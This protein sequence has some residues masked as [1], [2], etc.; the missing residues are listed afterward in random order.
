MYDEVALLQPST[1]AGLCP[2][3]TLPGGAPSPAAPAPLPPA[4]PFVEALAARGFSRVVGKDLWGPAR[5]PHMR[6]LL[7]RLSEG[8]TALVTAGLPPGLIAVFDEAWAL[9]DAVHAYL[10]GALPGHTVALLDWAVFHVPPAGGGAG[11]A[12]HRDRP[13]VCGAA[14]VDPATRLPRYVTAWL[15]LTPATPET[16]CLHFLPRDD[17]PGFND[18]ALPPGEC[19][20]Q[21]A[22]TAPEHFQRIVAVPAAPGA[23][24]AFGSRTLHYG[25]RPLP[26]LPSTGAARLPR[27]ALSFAFAVEGFEEPPCAAP[28]STLRARVA[29]AA[30]QAIVYAAQAPLPRGA[31]APLL[32]AFL[33]EAGAFGEAYARRVTAAGRWLCFKEKY[34]EGAAGGGGGAPD[35]GGV[36]LAFAGLAAAE[37][38]LDAAAYL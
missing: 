28:P 26:P 16:S 34:T 21:A 30:A 15:P 31:A 27:Q 4:P 29:L 8:V 37:L 17:D 38:G 22:V 25:S 12:P 35:E 24:L 10:R 19:P 9:H 11:W 23:L 20:L 2:N 13:S 14:A 32:G 7:S 36:R 1:F 6:A 3:L 33:S 5:L 18:G